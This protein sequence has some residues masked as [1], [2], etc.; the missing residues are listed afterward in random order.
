MTDDPLESAQQIVKHIRELR[1]A[2]RPLAE[3]W[4]H[5]E[6]VSSDD[7][8]TIT[9]TYGDLDRA[10]ALLDGAPQKKRVKPRPVDPEILRLCNLLADLYR[11]NGNK[12]PNPNQKSWHDACRLLM[13]KDGPDGAGWQVRQ[14]EIIMRWALQDE[15]WKG[16][17]QSMPTLRKQFDKL[18]AARN[19]EIHKLKAQEAQDPVVSQDWMIR[20]ASS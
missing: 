20:Q 4:V 15:F 2:L 11:D 3:H 14:I 13:T 18:R 12:R 9:I 16:N 5:D 17:I 6:T 7:E 19:R 1:D 10:K 8:L